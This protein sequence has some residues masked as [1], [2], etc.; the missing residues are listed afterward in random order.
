MKAIKIIYG[1][2]NFLMEQAR[3]QF[4][5]ACQQRAGGKAAVQTFDKESPAASVVE[6]FEGTSLFSSGSIIIWYE[7]PFL[8]IKKGGRSRSKVSVEEAWFLEKLANISEETGLLFYTQGMMDTGCAFY[9]QLQPIADVMQAA[10]VTEKNVMPYVEDFLTQK[11]KKLTGQA[12][13]YLRALF[14]TW[15]DISLLYVF[16]ELEKL[17]IMQPNHCADIDVGDLDN[18]FAGTMEKNLFTFMDYFLR[19]DGGRAVPLAEAL[20]ARPDMF[21]KN[22]GYMLSRLRLLLAYKELKRSRTGPRQCENI[23]MQIN[24]GRSVKYVLY[25]LQKVVSCWTIEELHEIISNIFV[26]QRNIR[27]GTASVSDMGPLVCLY[28]SHK[29]GV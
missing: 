10:P 4:I 25:H 29:G 14:Q 26:L 27:R 18:L 13:Q 28:C 8:P 17:C 3:H 9:K 7:C 24:K 15:S 21:L 11:G 20:F 12:F 23:M 1:K 6:A 19:R 22:T 16:S 5:A 2:E